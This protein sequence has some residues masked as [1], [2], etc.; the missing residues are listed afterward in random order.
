MAS[1]EAL[2]HSRY[3]DSLCKIGSGFKCVFGYHIGACDS[4]RIQS[5]KGYFRA[6]RM[7]AVAVGSACCRLRKIS[8]RRAR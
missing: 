8:A 7:T 3:L 6:H 5:F 2:E 4:K 1:S